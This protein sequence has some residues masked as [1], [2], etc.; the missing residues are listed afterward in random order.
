MSLSAFLFHRSLRL[1][2]NLGIIEA[3]KKEKNV[4]P[5]FCVDPRQA[6]PKGNRYFSYFSLGFMFQSLEDLKKQLNKQNSDLVLLYGIAENVIPGFLK[7][8]KVEKLYMNRDYTPFARKR[9]DKLKTKLQKESIELIEI[10]DYLLFP[11]CSIATKSGS[12]YRVYTP[13]TKI[14]L[15]KKVQKP[16]NLQNKKKL[17]S[18]SSLKSDSSSKAWNILKKY[19]KYAPFY[20]PGGREEGLKRLKNLPQ[21]QKYYDKCRDYLT[22]RTS[23]LSAYIKFGCVSIRE[24]WEAFGKVPGKAGKGLQRELLWREFYYHYYI[25][26]PEELEWDKKSREATLEKKAPD[27]VK[28]CLSELENSGYLHNRGRMILANYI[29][30]NQKNYWKEGDILYAK[31]LVDYDPFV[32]I[33]NWRWIEKQPPFRTLKPKT[34]YDKWDKGCPKMKKSQTEIEDGSYTDYWLHFKKK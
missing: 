14:A 20:V 19:S 26:Y 34:Q 16:T 15:R 30:K 10:E 2:D 17:A 7:K 1:D 28:A 31:R 3:L 18:A 12:I 4:I 8:K 13:F 33:G 21:S 22:Y 23:N 25:A 29:L 9:A 6:T 11:P 5:F 27:I 24:A 32:N